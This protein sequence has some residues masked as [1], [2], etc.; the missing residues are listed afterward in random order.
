MKKI[1]GWIRIGD[2]Q[3]KNLPWSNSTKYIFV[4][5]FND[6]FKCQNIGRK[7]KSRNYLTFIAHLLQSLRPFNVHVYEPS[8]EL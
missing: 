8:D 2:L 5:V 3:K 6:G 1:N 4:C 7:I